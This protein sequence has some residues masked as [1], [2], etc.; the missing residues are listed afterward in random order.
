[1]SSF[2]VVCI[3]L[4]VEELDETGWKDAATLWITFYVT[5]HPVFVFSFFYQHDEYF[6]FPERHFVVVIRFTI[7]ESAA[8]ST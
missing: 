5:F 6:T 3:L 1:M 2:L 4:F 7:V 8:S